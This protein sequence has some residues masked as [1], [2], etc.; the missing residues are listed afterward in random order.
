MIPRPNTDEYGAYY[1]GYIN[2]V[3]EGADVFAL[4]ASEPD[5]L[6]A[7][8]AGVTEEAASMRL[9]PTEWSI[10]EVLGHICDTERILSYRAAC[11]ARGDTTPLPGFEQDDYVNGTDFNA[12][13]LA[14][15]LDEFAALRKANLLTFRPLTDAELVRRGTAS[16]N[17]VTPRSLLYMLAGHVLHHVESLKVNYK[18]G[19]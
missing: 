11:V 5:D 18:L 16:N 7:L 12:R 15:L 9:N 14:D 8:L 10:K 1:G 2:R 13:T 3:P 4:L 19:N 6:R 17:P